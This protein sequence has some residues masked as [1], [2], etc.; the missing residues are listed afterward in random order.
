MFAR[1][2]WPAVGEPVR[3]A[4]E[5]PLIRFHGACERNGCL[6]SDTVDLCG[7]AAGGRALRYVRVQIE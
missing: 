2:V 3:L 6:P 5:K 4:V 1:P 7:Q